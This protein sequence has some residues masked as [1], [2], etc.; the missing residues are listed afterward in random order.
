MTSP[1]AATGEEAGSVAPLTAEEQKTLDALMARASAQGPAVRIGEPYRALIN[2]SVPRRGDKDKGSDLVAAGE[3]VYLTP[4]EARQFARHG[5]TDGRQ[6][7]VLQKLSGPDG[8]REELPRPGP[9]PGSG[10]VLRP[11]VPQPGSEAERPDPEGSSRVVTYDGR[12]P[13]TMG[14]VAPDPSEL[15][16]TLRSAAPDAVDLP[17]RSRR[18]GSR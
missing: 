17:P 5:N 1:A 15:A 8:S 4:E 7:S 12:A 11:P 9:R 10:R 3:T 14:A 2:L 6:I 18:A 16:D 13:E